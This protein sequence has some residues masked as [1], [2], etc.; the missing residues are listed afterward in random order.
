MND[1]ATTER[2]AGI[3]S[4]LTLE[5]SGPHTDYVSDEEWRRNANLWLVTIHHQLGRHH[6]FKFWMGAGLVTYEPARGR[7]SVE[8]PA[9]MA[10]DHY[11]PGIAAVAKPAEPQLGDLLACLASDARLGDE[12]FDD[13]CADLG[14]DT[15]SRK[16]EASWRQCRVDRDRLH[17]FFGADF[18]D[19]LDIDWEDL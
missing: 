7:R 3:L 12:T 9:R 2:A 17:A 18:D 13:F 15:D 19:F 6:Q 10:W 4:K 11:G 14:Y 16:A 1:T 5:L 8:P